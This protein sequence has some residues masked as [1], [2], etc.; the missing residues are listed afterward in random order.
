ML[1]DR[2][3]KNPFTLLN[4]KYILHSLEYKVKIFSKGNYC[5][6]FIIFSFTKLCEKIYMRK[7]KKIKTKKMNFIFL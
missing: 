6:P 3:N 1:I 4:K 2:I 5:I 7:D